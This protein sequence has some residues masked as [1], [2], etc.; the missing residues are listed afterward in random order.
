[1]A[2]PLLGGG[3]PRDL[4]FPF[5]CPQLAKVQNNV[6]LC[7][8]VIGRTQNMGGRQVKV[9]ARTW[10]S[11]F[12]HASHLLHLS[13]VNE[14]LCQIGGKNEN[15][16]Q[17][18]IDCMFLMTEK[19]IKSIGKNGGSQ[20]DCERAITF[21]SHVN[22]KN[23]KKAYISKSSC[24]TLSGC[25]TKILNGAKYI[26]DFTDVIKCALLMYILI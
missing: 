17:S 18:M 8:T 5:Y 16:N 24:T 22:G 26:D 11:I 14:F 10:K 6:A 23:L 4:T 3:N 13:E 19:I 7:C 25:S 12:L 2:L 15:W 21:W 20:C 1:M 9:K